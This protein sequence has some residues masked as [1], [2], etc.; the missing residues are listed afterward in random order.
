MLPLLVNT[1]RG[2]GLAGRGVGGSEAGARRKRAEIVD[3]VALDRLE[4]TM[5]SKV[6]RIEKREHDAWCTYSRLRHSLKRN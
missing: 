2:E 6:D 4:I 5:S 1:S 3:A